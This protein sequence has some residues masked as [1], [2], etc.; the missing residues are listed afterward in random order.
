MF[1]QGFMKCIPLKLIY[2]VISRPL[3]SGGSEK[4]TEIEMDNLL[5][6]GISLPV[7]F[8]PMSPK[9]LLTYPHK[10]EDWEIAMASLFLRL[11]LLKVLPDQLK[12]FC[13]LD[14]LFYQ[15][16]DHFVCFDLL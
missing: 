3:E 9:L 12:I 1:L 11:I 14:R 13:Q 16:F 4:R 7:N 2:V 5:L 10:E 8:S 15:M 6:L